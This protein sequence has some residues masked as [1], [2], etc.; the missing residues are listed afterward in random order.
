[1]RCVPNNTGQQ[2]TVNDAY[3][4]QSQ[5]SQRALCIKTDGLPVVV[6]HDVKQSSLLNHTAVDSD[7]AVI[8]PKFISTVEPG[9]T[10]FGVNMH[11]QRVDGLAFQSGKNN[12][13][14]VRIES[15]FN[16]EFKQVI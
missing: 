6:R 7:Y 10:H 5:C 12:S 9:T 2:T 1:M 16:L 4:N 14:Y 3:L 8:S 11:L 15:T 13:Q